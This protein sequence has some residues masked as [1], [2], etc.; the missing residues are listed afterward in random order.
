MSEDL[1]RKN[2]ILQELRACEIQYADLSKQVKRIIVENECL[3]AKST[4]LMTLLKSEFPLAADEIIME[5]DRE[6]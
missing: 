2:F 4:R 3:E 6:D 1:E 5:T